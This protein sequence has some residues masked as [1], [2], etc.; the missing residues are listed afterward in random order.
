[1]NKDNT[2]STPD[3]THITPETPRPTRVC[4]GSQCLPGASPPG[5]AKYRTQCPIHLANL[6]RASKRG[7]LNFDASTLVARGQ[8]SRTRAAA[9]YVYALQYHACAESVIVRIHQ[10]HSLLPGPRM[11]IEISHHTH[12][13][14]FCL[15]PLLVGR[16]M[17]YQRRTSPA[18][19]WVR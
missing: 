10:H 3:S 1:M 18:S 19:A 2:Y 12:T 9:R 7:V 15:A 14:I 11:A 8:R 6:L 5:L 4:C 16:R 17:T 13:H